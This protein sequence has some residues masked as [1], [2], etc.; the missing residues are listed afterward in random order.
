MC[1]GFE[2]FT[3][4]PNISLLFCIE[5]NWIGTIEIGRFIFLMVKLDTVWS[6][7]YYWLVVL[8]EWKRGFKMWSILGPANHNFFY[9]DYYS[10]VCKDSDFRK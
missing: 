6:E 8:S 10:I 3:F 5:N 9:F 1:Y 4:W 7:Q 2:L